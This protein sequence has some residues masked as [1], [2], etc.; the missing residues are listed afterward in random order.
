MNTCKDLTVERLREALDYNPENGKFTWKYKITTNTK[1]WRAAGY[2]DT[3]GYWRIK[4]D[5]YQHRAHRL[6]WFYVN[7]EWPPMDLDHI[8][9]I[10]S[11]N[12]IEN[13]RLAT[14]SLNGENLRG[15]RKDNKSGLLGVITRE[16][17][18]QS[19]IHVK[20]KNIYLGSFSSAQEAHNAYLLAKRK[21][22]EGCTI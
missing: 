14:A 18:F 7:G 20:G 22:H 19:K 5:G 9:G 10:K 6:A 12:R 16:G 3:K 11:D 13:L 2:L 17:F 8:N 15:A 1:M 21:L 4:L